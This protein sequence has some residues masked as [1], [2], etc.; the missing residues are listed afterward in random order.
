MRFTFLPFAALASLATAQYIALIGGAD[1]ETHVYLPDTA[2]VDAL[3]P[4]MATSESA[5]PP[6]A[7]RF[8]ATLDKSARRQKLVDDRAAQRVL[9]ADTDNSNSDGVSLLMTDALGVNR[10]ISIFAGLVRQVETLM[11]RLQDPT[12]N[13]L[14]LAP[15][16]VAMQAFPRKPWEDAPGTVDDV[17][18]HSP[19]DDER[20]AMKNIETFVLS[21]VVFDYSFAGPEHRKTSAAGS[22]ELWYEAGETNIVHSSGPVGELSAK[23]LAVEGTGNGQVWT[24]DRVLN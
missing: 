20:R 4:F 21:Q 6:A 16:N 5:S 22:A 11:Y 2:D 7:D 23:V 15:T 14:V 1:H 12:K 10:E 18:S 24:V 8:A 19:M 13:T 17:H 3:Q 9:Y